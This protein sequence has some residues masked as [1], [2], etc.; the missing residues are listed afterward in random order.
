MPSRRKKK[1]LI[2]AALG[3]GM[4]VALSGC[5][6]DTGK[7]ARKR[8]SKTAD[9]DTGAAGSKAPSTGSSKTSAPVSPTGK[10]PLVAGWQTQTA[11]KHH[12]RFDVPAKAKKWKVLDEGTSLSYTDKNGKPIVVMTGTA[13]YREGGCGSSPNPKAFGEAGKG[14]LATVGTT[15]GGKTGTLQE[16]ARNWAGNW[17]FAAYGG[18]EHKPEIK[19]SQP[20]P[21]KQGGIE[22]YTATAEVTVTNRPGSCVPPKAVVHSI[23]QKLPDGTMHGWVI[24]ADQGV[25]KALTA[26]EIKKIMSTVRSTGS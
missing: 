22:G 21:W 3:I 26:A 4:A 16:N 6:E 24:Y 25:P 10:K 8:T 9:K 18:E 12:F 13:N 5:N 17:G 2:A 14:Q 1:T 23:A 19:V 15:G 7:S 20:K 11:Q